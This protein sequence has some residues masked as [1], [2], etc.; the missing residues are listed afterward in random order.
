MSRY[1]TIHWDRIGRDLWLAAFRF[2][3]KTLRVVER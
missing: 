1:C 3:P 2:D